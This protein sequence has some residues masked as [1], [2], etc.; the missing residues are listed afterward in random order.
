MMTPLRS[1]QRFL[2]SAL[3]SLSV[4]FI[5]SSAAL[6]TGLDNPIGPTTMTTRD[7]VLRLTR[8]MLGAGGAFAVFAFIYGGLL[9]LLARGNSEMV[10]KAK[11]SLVWAILGM[12]TMLL[13]YAFL[14]FV[15]DALATPTAIE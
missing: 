8:T 12:A 10:K 6:A 3:L 7:L 2:P 5:V 13:S 14:K 1:I 11:D 4:F 9:M 15:W